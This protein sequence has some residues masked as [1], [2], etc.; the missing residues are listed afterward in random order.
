MA[1]SS[2]PHVCSVSG[3]PGAAC[4]CVTSALSQTQWPTWEG[5]GRNPWHLAGPRRGQWQ[6]HLSE[7]PL[8]WLHVKLEAWLWL[9]EIFPPPFTVLRFTL[10]LKLSISG[11][12]VCK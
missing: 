11:S 4:R 5:W 9:L 10:L 3:V 2:A 7:E 6:G 12:L 1:N 8:R